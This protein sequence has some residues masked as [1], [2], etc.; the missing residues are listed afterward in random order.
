MASRKPILLW[1]GNCSFCIRWIQRWRKIT[2]NTIDDHPYQEALPDHPEVT[3]ADCKEAIQLIMP[4]GHIYQAA[5]ALLQSFAISGKGKK[6][7]KLYHRSPLFRHIA[8]S[9]YR[10]IARNRSWLPR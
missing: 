7:L 9:S 4:D 5:H 3:E 10:F 6:L 1:D 8:E 2:Q